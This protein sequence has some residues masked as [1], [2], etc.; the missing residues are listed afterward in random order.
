MRISA[1]VYDAVD[2]IAAL[3]MRRAL[4]YSRASTS[5][6]IY[7]RD[8]DPIEERC[9][10]CIEDAAS[11][12]GYSILC[13]D[14]YNTSDCYKKACNPPSPPGPPPPPPTYPPKTVEVV[15]ECARWDSRNICSTT[16]VD[17]ESCTKAC[18]SGCQ[19]A[20]GGYACCRREYYCAEST[21]CTYFSGSCTGSPFPDP[22]AFHTQCVTAAGTTLC[23]EGWHQY[24]WI[25]T[26]ANGARDQGCAF[27]LW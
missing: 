26:C 27:C 16:F 14:I 19:S 5:T 15:E 4:N 7:Q 23:C 18:D 6:A 10:S 21:Q 1:F 8:K 13:C 20:P 17:L 3:D 2:M 24:P 9:G 22:A 25:K 11:K 12:T